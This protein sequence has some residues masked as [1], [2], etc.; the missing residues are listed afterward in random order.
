MLHHTLTLSFVILQL[1]FSSG[2]LSVAK[3]AASVLWN[4]FVKEPEL[5][6]ENTDIQTASTDM[7]ISL[8]RLFFLLLPSI[9]LL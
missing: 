2:V 3:S 1:S 8:Q 4:H 6:K 5:S 9:S 7:C